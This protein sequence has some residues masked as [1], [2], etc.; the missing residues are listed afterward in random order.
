MNKGI[1]EAFEKYLQLIS[2]YPV[3][4]FLFLAMLVF[5]FLLWINRNTKVTY[6]L[7]FSALLLYL[8]VIA[9]TRRLELFQ[10]ITTFFHGNF[11]QNMYFYYWNMAI[12]GYFLHANISSRRVAD[13][14]KGIS[15]L[16]FIVLATNAIYQLYLS[17][18][19]HQNAILI[20]GNTYPLILFGNLLAF[21]YYLYLII[22][23]FVFY[24]KVKKHR[25]DKN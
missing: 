16:F 18:V 10:N 9:F 24:K 2:D 23:F 20:L 25:F 7:T 11:Y 13:P 21:L 19:V 6:Y 15:I 3:F 22:Y 17:Q 5:G 8:V 4:L 14:K 12:V 1:T